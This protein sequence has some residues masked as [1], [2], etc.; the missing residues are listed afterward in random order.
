MR[1]TYRFI[2]RDYWVD[3][4]DGTVK[5]SY[6]GAIRTA[7]PYEVNILCTKLL[8]DELGIGVERMDKD[9]TNL[10]KVAL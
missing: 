10:H 2:N 3:D 6:E 4:F 8:S 5:V 1:K 9:A 7:F